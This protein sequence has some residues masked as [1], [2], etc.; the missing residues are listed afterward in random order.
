MGFKLPKED[1]TK[2]VKLTIK[3]YFFVD[4]KCFNFF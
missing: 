4:K 2:L 1:A 3:L